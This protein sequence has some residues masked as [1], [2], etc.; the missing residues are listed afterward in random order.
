[1]EEE[2]IGPQKQASHAVTRSPGRL[3]TLMGSCKVSVSHSIGG[4]AL[5]A[6]VSL[7]WEFNHLGLREEAVG[8]TLLPLDFSVG[9]K[10]ES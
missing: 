8:S 5:L 4:R 1:M 7:G 10:G 6:E 9:S 3:S 2:R